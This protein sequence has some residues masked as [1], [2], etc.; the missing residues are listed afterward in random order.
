FLNTLIFVLLFIGQINLAQDKKKIQFTGAA[1]SIVSNSEINVKDEV[2]DTVTAR[3]NLGGYALIDLGVNIFPNK[4]TEIMGMFRI[5]NRFGGFYGAGVNFDVRQLYLKGVI[6]NAVRYQLGDVNYKLTPYTFYCHDEDYNVKMPEL[7]NLQ[8]EIVNYEA[9]Y[10]QNTWRQQ[11]GIVDFSL[12]FSKWIQEIKFNGF[13]HRV[14][15]S[16]FNATAD[17]IFTGGNIGVQQSKN[18]FI[19]WNYVS[20]LDL[21]G[22]S[23]EESNFRNNVSSL[24]AEYKISK[25]K[26]EVSFSGEAGMSSYSNTYDSLFP[27]INGDFVN[28]SLNINIKPVNTKFSFGYMN[29]SPDFRSAGAQSKRINYNATNSIYDRYTNTQI[30]RPVGLFDMMNDATIYNRSISNNLMMYNP[31]YNNV[32]PFG[33]ATFNRQGMYV[34]ADFNTKK[35]AVKAGAELYSL[36][37]VKGQGTNK[38]K[39]FLLAKAYTEINFH[40]LFDLKR[41]I[42]INGGYSF[43]NTNRSSDISFEKINLNSSTISA[44]AE[45]EVFENFDLLAGYFSNQAKGNELMSERNSY[46]E[47]TDFTEYHVELNESIL[48]AGIRYRFSEKVYLS[49]LYQNYQNKNLMNKNLSYSINQFQVIFNMKY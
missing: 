16:D 48:G 49:A 37:E 14:N 23:A 31:A 5:N 13:A 25:E 34:K 42:K 20:L 28:A 47:V 18:L 38:L 39:S 36:N 35:D 19:G 15:L 32:L 1:R 12:E 22:T 10:R 43:Q 21:L 11:G 30:L 3:K 8:R 17:R 7:F 41:I 27:A 2:E 33:V 29:V 4:N 26:F 44:G 6:A 40:K 45:Y 46:T 24:N 9:F